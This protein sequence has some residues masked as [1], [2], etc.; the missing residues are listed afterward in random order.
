MM[1][2]VEKVDG[3]LIASSHV[4][5]KVMYKNLSDTRLTGVL[6]K[7][8]IPSEVKFA[9]ATAGNYDEVS[10][11]LTLNQDSIDAYSEGVI[12]ITG[13]VIIDAP[14]GKT[15]VTTVYALYTVPGTKAQDEVTAY[16]VGSILPAENISKVDT[17][18]KKVVGN[19]SDRGFMPNNLVEWLAL[20]AII[21]II[22]I[23]GRS[24]YVSYK[25]DEGEV[26]QH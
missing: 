12:T 11:T 3:K 9:S 16:V 13:D 1:L 24:I 2:Q 22:F 25:E 7:V 17:G 21:F 6:L 14:V 15:I 8:T 5:Y 18:A 23:L 26:S 4:T 20:I 19:S 10:H